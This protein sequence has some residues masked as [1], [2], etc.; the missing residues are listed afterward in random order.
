MIHIHRCQ[1]I[2]VKYCIFFWLKHLNKM[3]FHHVF[4]ANVS[5]NL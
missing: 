2:E 5:G 4:T 3:C 1:Y